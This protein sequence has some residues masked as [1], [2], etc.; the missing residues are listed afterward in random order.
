MSYSYDELTNEILKRIHEEV[1]KTHYTTGDAN[2]TIFLSIPLFRRI[3]ASLDQLML[4][5]HSDFRS[6]KLF[7]CNVEKYE[8]QGLAFYV[9]TAKKMTY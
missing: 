3:H 5:A 1:L 8:D 4:Y 6:T 2:I 7:G 9:T